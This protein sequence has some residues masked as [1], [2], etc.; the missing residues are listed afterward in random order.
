M[1][2]ATTTTYAG[3]YR[4]SRA[5]PWTKLATADNYDD[6]W[7]KLLDRLPLGRGGESTV[8][9]DGALPS[10]VISHERSLK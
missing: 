6:C 9:R 5:A 3:W 2:T 4:P 10:G 7:G 1:S 8:I